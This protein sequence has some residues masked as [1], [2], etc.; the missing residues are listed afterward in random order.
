MADGDDVQPPEGSSFGGPGSVSLEDVDASRANQKADLTKVTLDGDD[1]PDDL[2]GKTAADL[3]QR[4]RALENA[5]KISEDG[6]KNAETLAQIASRGTAAPATAPAPTPV[7]EQDMPAEEL[8]QLMQTDPGK[9]VQVIQEQTARKVDAQVRARLGPIAS[10]ASG[11]AEATARQKYAEEFALFG[12]EI[13]RYTDSLPNKDILSNPAAWDDL[14]SYVRGRPGN[15]EKLFDYRAGKA[16]EVEAVKA[17]ESQV[18]GV[19][20]TSRPANTAPATRKGR[21]L[22]A[23]EREIARELGLDDNEYMKWRDI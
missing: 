3:V 14:V 20:F 9:A 15:F 19:G 10:G 8:A 22:D 23:T 18:N 6:R 21:P 11:L 16:R 17:R 2:K 12:D 4:T 7:V 13:K 1:I 5:L